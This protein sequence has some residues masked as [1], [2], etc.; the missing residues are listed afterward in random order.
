M[1]VFIGLLFA[2]LFLYRCGIVQ[3]TSTVVE[4]AIVK[5]NQNEGTTSW[6]IEVPEKRCQ[7]PDHQWCRRPQIEG[8]CSQ[9]TY[10]TGDSLKIFVSTDP[11]SAYTLDLFRMGYYG[12]NGG[13]LMKSAGRL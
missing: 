3:D 1:R 7:L 4:N 11:A 9:T 6:M 8:Y 13:R 5:E 2:S 10:E 12:G